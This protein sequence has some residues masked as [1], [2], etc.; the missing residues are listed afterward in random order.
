MLFKFK[1][2]LGDSKPSPE[3]AQA[4]LTRYVNRK[5]STFLTY[6]T[7]VKEFMTWYGSKLD[8]KIKTPKPTPAYHTEGQIQSLVEV[9]KSKKTHKKLAI[10]DSLLIGLAATTDKFPCVADFTV[11]LS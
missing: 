11:F 10:R 3:L 5:P 9:T 2:Y 7:Y 1:D 4:F 6:F 8:I